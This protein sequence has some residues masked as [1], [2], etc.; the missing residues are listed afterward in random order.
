MD[1]Q[2]RETLG[3]SCAMIESGGI[4]YRQIMWTRPLERDV[5]SGGAFS[6][7]F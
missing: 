6:S 2:A 4:L 7:A 3:L 5:D 1:Q